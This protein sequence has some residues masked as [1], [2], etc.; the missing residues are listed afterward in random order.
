MES[1]PFNKTASLLTYT[2]SHFC[3]DFAC[4]Y[5]LFHGFKNSVTSGESLAIGFLIYNLV[6]FGIQPFIGYLCDA[7]R[8]IPIAFYGCCLLISGLALISFSWFS[9]VICAFGNACFHVGG[10]IDSLVYANGKI[11]RSGVFVSSGALGVVLGTLAGKNERVS[12]IVP[13]LL[14]VLC[15]ILIIRF[16]RFK[17]NGQVIINF[18]IT[19]L[20]Q[21]FSFVMVLCCL[22]VIIRSYVGASIPIEWRTT[23]MLVLLPSAGA[24]LG[25][26]AGG[27]LA[28]LFGARN[29]GVVSLIASMPFLCFGY[30]EPV[31]CTIGIILFNMT[32]PITLC[33]IAD[34]LEQNPGLS[35][36][37]TT[38]WLLCGS[39]PVFFFKLSTIV[40]IP[41]ISV[42]III[43]VVCIYI[44]I[45]NRE[46]ELKHDKPYQSF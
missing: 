10:G 15:C 13:V 42:L 41:A 44:S 7:K 31:L 30:N 23:T 45:I 2:F 22:T 46:G 35:F 5:M 24:T 18:N 20:T 12:I 34:K 11:S 1:V 8:N 36:G 26:T 39:I 33:A 43:S 21:P 32:M 27:Y 19:S 4:F 25:K 14:L 6:A 40:V 17:Y 3:V 37:L 28:D 38:L 29:V 16:T 9:L